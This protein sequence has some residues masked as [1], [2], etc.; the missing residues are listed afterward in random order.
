VHR[1]YRGEAIRQLIE[2]VHPENAE[3]FET[4]QLIRHCLMHGRRIASVLDQLPCDGHQALNRL[5][6]VAWRAIGLMFGNPDPRPESPLTL[7]YCDDLVRRT[8]VARGYLSLPPC[9]AAIPTI[10]SSPISQ[11]S[12]WW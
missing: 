8:L 9:Y 2:R 5:A 4:L 3:V 10:R 1:R 7:G 6:V 12:T 11:P